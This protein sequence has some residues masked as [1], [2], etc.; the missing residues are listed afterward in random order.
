MWEYYLAGSEVSYRHMGTTLFQIQMV[1]NRE[2]VPMTRDYIAK[3]EKRIASP[4]AAYPKLS[5]LFSVIQNSSLSMR[6]QEV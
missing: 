4:G 1:K 2:S 3:S 5:P 6:C